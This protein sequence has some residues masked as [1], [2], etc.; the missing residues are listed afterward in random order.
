[1]NT[2][3]ERVCPGGTFAFGAEFVHLRL[4]AVNHNVDGGVAVDCNGRE[5]MQ[6]IY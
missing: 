1:M 6:R 3:Y 4:R 2:G 5:R